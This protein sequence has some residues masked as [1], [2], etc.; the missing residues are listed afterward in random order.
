MCGIGGSEDVLPG[1]ANVSGRKPLS[2]AFRMAVLAG[3]VESVRLHL[4]SGG[5]VNATDEKGRSP[6]ILAASRGHLDICQLL[7]EEGADPAIKDHEG[8]DALSVAVSRGQNEIAALLAVAHGLAE[9]PLPSEGVTGKG[10]DI[11]TFCDVL[12]HTGETG[13]RADMIEATAD[14]PPV[15]LI[16]PHVPDGG[17]RDGIGLLTPTR[18]ADEMVDLS[19]WQEEIEG[20]LRR[21]IPLV[22]MARPFFRSCC[23]ATFLSTQTRAGTTSRSICRRRAIS[24]AG[25]HL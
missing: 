23:P 19:A 14:L 15:S 6:L 1:A 5:D 17:I 24:C 21:M 10:Q 4:R 11:G 7:L 20:P 25:T 13:E 12:A 16:V 3:A 18:D 9:E 2:P 8:N 22:P